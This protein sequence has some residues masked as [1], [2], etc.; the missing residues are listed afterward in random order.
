VLRP[1]GEAAGAPAAGP[2]GSEALEGF[3]RLLA[4][5]LDE[6]WRSGA[7][8]ERAAAEPLEPATLP[9]DPEPPAAA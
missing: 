6:Q 3:I 1:S 7:L 8:T 4:R 9:T 5:L 2:T